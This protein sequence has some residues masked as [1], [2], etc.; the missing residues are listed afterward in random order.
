ML[1][2]SFHKPLRT[3]NSSTIIDWQLSV[4][5][6]LL[7]G[8]TPWRWS[9]ICVYFLLPA[10][11]VMLIPLCVWQIS[12]SLIHIENPYGKFFR[13]LTNV[14]LQI[15]VKWTSDNVE[16]QYLS[17]MFVLEGIFQQMLL[18]ERHITVDVWSLKLLVIGRK[19][20]KRENMHKFLFFFPQG[21]QQLEKTVGS[22]DTWWQQLS[23]QQAKR[24]R[25]K[26]TFQN[27]NK[28]QFT[29]CQA[30]LSAILQEITSAIHVS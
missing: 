28:A 24:Y 22:T 4:C 6:I 8:H 20:M 2:I 21:Q 14:S 17:S 25:L 3:A 5:T 18:L 29:I 16:F 12:L 7:D 1:A 26:P 10:T 19:K 27:K 23:K 9:L 15:Y 11:I 13:M 30:T